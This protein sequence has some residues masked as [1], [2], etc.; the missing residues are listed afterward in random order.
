MIRRA[1]NGS[2]NAPGPTLRLAAVRGRDKNRF[3]VHGHHAE[4]VDRA[5]VADK[6]A[7]RSAN[8]VDRGFSFRAAE[9]AGYLL[10]SRRT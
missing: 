8:R 10:I 7:S 1:S 3:A 9:R 5:A 6:G 4:L 2:I